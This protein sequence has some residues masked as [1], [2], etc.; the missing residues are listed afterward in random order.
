MI[1]RGQVYWV[2]LDPV[3]GS[4][5]AK[6]RPCV[7]V[8]SEEVNDHRKTV[9]VVPLTST[10]TPAVP[11]LLVSVPSAGADSK[12]RVEQIRA[13]DKSRLQELLGR[14]EDEDLREIEVSLQRILKIRPI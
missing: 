14:L 8:S 9:I 12:A 5:Q 3:Q 2:R 11:P 10:K 7:V 4:E 13:V 1:A 6:T